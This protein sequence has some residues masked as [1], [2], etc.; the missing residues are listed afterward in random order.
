MAIGR[1]NLDIQVRAR[2][3]SK[4]LNKISQKFSSTINSI[5]DM[6]S[7]LKLGSL[8]MSGVNG[9]VDEYMAK[10]K[11]LANLHERGFSKEQ[12]Q[13]ILDLS[14][15][16][17]NLGYSAEVA[18]EAF[19]Q[20]VTTG[21][22]SSLQAIGIY[23]DKN[24][25]ST[26]LNADAQQ[27]LNWVLENG[28]KSLDEQRKS[29]PEHIRNQLE[30]RKAIDDTKKALGASFLKAISNIVNAFGGLSNTLKIALGVFAAYRTAM[31][32]GNVAIGIAKA[33]A[34]GGVFAAPIAIGLGVSALAAIGA[35]IGGSIIAGNSLSQSAS[36][37]ET[38]DPKVQVSNVVEVSLNSDR[39]GEVQNIN[40]SNIGRNN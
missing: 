24:T 18:N 28:N 5:K 15:N 31:I 38:N 32:L 27:R 36:A 3:I 22:A 26:L 12:S 1:V 19:T 10:M 16:F 8:F 2:N 34:Q 40:G 37:S 21:K 35:L 11:L 25:R 14:D 30:M 20:F 29:M 4:E 39:F 9:V 13:N 6:F 33:I 7:G 17:E 23:L